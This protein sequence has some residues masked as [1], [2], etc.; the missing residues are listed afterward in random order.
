MTLLHTIRRLLRHA[1]IETHRATPMTMWELRLPKL[2]A[3]HKVQTVLDVGANDGG[4]AAELIGGGYQKEVLSFEPLPDAW[5]ALG[6]RAC[7]HPNW[8]V[9]PRMALSD[10][11]GEA[12]FYE[13]G[14][15]VSS[16]LL[17]MAETHRAASPQSQPL[18]T[19][20]VQTRRLDDVL[21]TLT[22]NS[23]FYLKIDVQGAERLVLDGASQSLLSSIV[24]VQLE[25]S[26]AT[27]YDNQA[28]AAQLD[29]FMTSLG[30]ECWDV[31]PGFRDPSTL[32]MLQYDGIYFRTPPPDRT[33]L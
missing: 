16:S 18:G 27:L 21:P 25:M 15:S 1:Q 9:A 19:I 10:T 30:F 28:S 20:K 11:N 33:R 7:S 17:P 6:N 24:G 31:L 29:E 32:R 14:N 8:K 5:D 2:L 12:D 13:A 23:P 4:F 3:H 26:V 22:E